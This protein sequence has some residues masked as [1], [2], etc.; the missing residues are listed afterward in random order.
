MV[1]LFVQC[2]PI[3]KMISDP[4]K[5]PHIWLY[6][7]KQ[8]NIVSQRPQS[9]N[10]IGHSAGR[11][12]AKTFCRYPS[13]LFI[14]PSR[15]YS[16]PCYTATAP[17]I[18]PEKVLV[19]TVSGSWSPKGHRAHVATLLQF[20]PG[21][22][23]YSIS[24]C[25]QHFTELF[26]HSDGVSGRMFAPLTK[27]PKQ[28]IWKV[29]WAAFL[30]LDGLTFETEKKSVSWCNAWMK[31]DSSFSYLHKPQVPQDTLLNRCIC[32]TE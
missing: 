19:P 29:S 23:L 27:C 5:K 14:H 13:I 17:S 15:V 21:H 26:T 25:W 24:A 1:V 22:P 16:K 31:T 3:R 9:V 32:L 11:D 7:R 10:Q 12:D 2:F 20:R 4:W 30:T 18:H 6:L 8:T 28:C